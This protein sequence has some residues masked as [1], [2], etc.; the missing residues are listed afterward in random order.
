[1]TQSLAQRHFKVTLESKG[2]SLFLH[3]S[4]LEHIKRP[5][6]SYNQAAAA[7]VYSDTSSGTKAFHGH[8]LL[9]SP[10]RLNESDLLGEPGKEVYEG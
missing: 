1:M 4:L 5:R 7:S 6:L 3:M 2:V 8:P 9:L 10:G